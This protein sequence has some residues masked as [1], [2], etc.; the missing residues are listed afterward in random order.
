MSDTIRAW[1][2]VEHGAPEVLRLDEVPLPEPGPG[3]V[4]VRMEAMALNH[5]DLWVRRGIPGVRFPLPLVPGSDGAG[6]VDAV[7]PGVAGIEPGT[8]VFVL[9]GVS[10]GRC[11]ACLAG[12]DNYCREYGILGESRDGTSAEAI[13]LPATNVAP[14]PPRLSLEEAASFGLVYL[15]AWHMLVHKARVR[16]GERVL[17]HAAASGVSS[18]GIQIAR[19]HGA[20]VVATAGSPEKLALARDLGAEE[21]FDYRE[22]DWPARV[23]EWAGPDGIDIVF[24]H[25]GEQTF[26]PSLRVLGRGGR[27][28]FCGAT[29]GPRLEADMRL[30]FFRNFEVLGS[31]MGRRA[32]LLR[33]A[34]LLAA[35]RLRA[36]V[37]PHTFTFE[38]LP[39]AHRHLEER[40]AL[41]KVVVRFGR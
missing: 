20:R 9:P 24:D 38:D 6:T 17:V 37:D 40:R 8:R 14:V 22:E 18:A 36:V 21:A 13:V 3:E 30:V 28:V 16:A 15:T 7:G 33:V 1:R 32:D 12:R 23:R 34:D 19:L 27:Y 10:C 11:A 41:G 5:L 2:I 26:G 29:T 31:T 25:V 39:A 35:G 4:R